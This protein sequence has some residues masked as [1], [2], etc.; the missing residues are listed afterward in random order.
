MVRVDEVKRA[1]ASLYAAQAN[2]CYHEMRAADRRERQGL[3]GIAVI[4]AIQ[5]ALIGWVVSFLF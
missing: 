2:K 5:L 1:R 3:I 4:A